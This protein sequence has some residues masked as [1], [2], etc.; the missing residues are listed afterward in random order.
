MRATNFSFILWKEAIVRSS[1]RQKGKLWSQQLAGKPHPLV[2]GHDPH[3]PTP[4]MMPGVCCRLLWVALV[5]VLPLGHGGMAWVGC[6]SEA[7]CSLNGACEGGVCSCRPGWS[8]RDCAALDLRPADPEREGHSYVAP[9]GFSAWGMSVVSSVD[10]ASEY[11]GYVST[12]LNGCKLGSWRTNSV[13]T[14]RGS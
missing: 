9:F 1:A 5:V 4:A 13:G 12:F 6:R 14:G 7:E 10:N 11:H 2:S 3:C 8:G